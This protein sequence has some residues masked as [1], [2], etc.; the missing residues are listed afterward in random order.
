VA[1]A[2]LTKLLLPDMLA[3]KTGD[4]LFVASI[5]AFL[6]APFFA[7]YAASKAYLRSFGE[8]LG[9]EL[10]GTGVRVTVLSP[11]GTATEFQRVAGMTPTRL[12][13]LGT[14]PADAVARI[15]LRA[16][17]RGRRSVIAG[18]MNKVMMWLACRLLPLRLRLHAAALFQKA[19]GG[20]NS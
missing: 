13:K 1:P 14:M 12:A 9:H 18:V 5:A 19:A 20:G 16:L 17:A 8:A 4:I 6:P 2:E 7:S 15:G 10:R 3:R 11:G